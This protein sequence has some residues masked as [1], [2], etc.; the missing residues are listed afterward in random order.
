MAGVSNVHRTYGFF[1]APA[2]EPFPIP[3]PEP[4]PFGGGIIVPDTFDGSEVSMKF[5]RFRGSS[6][7]S[8]QPTARNSALAARRVVIAFITIKGNV[9]RG[10]GFRQ[11]TTELGVLITTRRVYY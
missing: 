8:L 4:F 9:R 5:G 3:G 1:G 10:Y 6:F 2:P 11:A 7:F